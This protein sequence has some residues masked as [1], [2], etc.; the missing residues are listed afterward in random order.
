[1]NKGMDDMDGKIDTEAD[2][3]DEDSASHCINIQ[4]PEVNDA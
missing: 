1:M 4:A 3:D 2:T